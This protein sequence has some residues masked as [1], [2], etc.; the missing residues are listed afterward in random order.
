MTT[1]W[2]FLAHRERHL[3]CT[4]VTELCTVACD[5]L[6]SQTILV[7]RAEVREGLLV[8]CVRESRGV[9]DRV[10]SSLRWKSDDT[11]IQEDEGP[12]GEEVSDAYGRVCVLR[13]TVY[14]CRVAS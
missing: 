3:Q 10:M 8:F 14:E 4:C 2:K 11:S 13:I 6:D 5:S 9:E 7:E 12:S 1:S